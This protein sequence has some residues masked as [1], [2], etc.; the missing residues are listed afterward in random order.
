MKTKIANLLASGAS[1]AQVARAVGVTA[2]YISQLLTGD[3]EF[4]A[5]LGKVSSEKLEEDIALEAAYKNVEV[6]IL[7]QMEDK[8]PT[9]DIRELSLALGAVT[10]KKQRAAPSGM[11]NGLSVAVSVHLPAHMAETLDIEVVKN[12]RSE[13]VEI[14]GR[15]FRGLTES[16]FTDNLV[17]LKETNRGVIHHDTEKSFESSPISRRLEEI[18]KVASSCS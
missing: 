3:K 9:A 17:S 14:E 15:N 16:E 11:T 8:L 2:S 7:E 10:A 13:I 6:G 1:P 5:I 18:S 4:E 12:A